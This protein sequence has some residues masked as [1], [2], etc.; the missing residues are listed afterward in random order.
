MLLQL[1]A[2]RIKAD[3]QLRVRTRWRLRQGRENTRTQSND[4]MFLDDLCKVLELNK[5][6]AQ[7]QIIDHCGDWGSE[8]AHDLSW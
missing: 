2:E 6:R 3:L 7:H 4:H 1:V 8:K 5:R